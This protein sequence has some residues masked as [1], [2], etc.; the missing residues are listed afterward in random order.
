M[1]SKLYKNT[2]SFFFFDTFPRSSEEQISLEN[3]I[4]DV[5]AD[6]RKEKLTRHEAWSSLI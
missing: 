2:F 4:K 6:R 3:L 5:R 1:R